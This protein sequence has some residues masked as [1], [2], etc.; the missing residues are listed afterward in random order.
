ML[1]GVS[2]SIPLNVKPNRAERR[3]S[4]R[5][6]FRYGVRAAVVRALTGARIYLN[7]FVSTLA[8]AAYGCGSNV[9]YVR[10]AVIVLKS[11]NTALLDQVLEGDLPLL[12]AARQV[13]QLGKLVAAYRGA[14]AA[15]RVAFARA[16][17]PSTLFDDSLVPALR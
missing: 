2:S 17:G 4:S 9:I 13:E 15:D 6:R 7:G 5:R 12:E 10:A 3:R 11:E 8:A 16:I 14:S 1:N